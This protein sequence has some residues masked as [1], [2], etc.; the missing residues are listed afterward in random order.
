MRQFGK[1]LRVEIET[2][3]LGRLRPAVTL[4]PPRGA[5]AVEE[6]FRSVG[7]QRPIG[8]VIVKQHF[9]GPA[10]LDAHQE[11]PLGVPP[12]MIALRTDE[13]FRSVRSPT[14]DRVAGAVKRDLTRRAPAI[15]HPV[16]LSATITPADNA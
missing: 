15:G 6:K 4:A 12:E 14:V 13:E 16:Y 8:P 10:F 1:C 3:N 11:E 5:F 2:P 9:L 7:R